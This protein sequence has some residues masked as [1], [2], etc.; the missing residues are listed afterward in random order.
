MAGG[1]HMSGCHV[2]T[3]FPSLSS[4]P[5][6]CCGTNGMGSVHVDRFSCQNDR[7]A[8]MWLPG[9]TL[10]GQVPDSCLGNIYF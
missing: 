9:T 8:V 4:L 1:I 2:I 10:S 6:C 5:G 3:F 7:V